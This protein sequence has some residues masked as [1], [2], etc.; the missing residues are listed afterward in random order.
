M[1]LINYYTL[2]YKVL[3]HSKNLYNLFN[4][5]IYTLVASTGKYTSYLLFQVIPPSLEIIHSTFIGE[6]ILFLH[7][8]NITI[9][10]SF[11]YVTAG[12]PSRLSPLPAIISS[13]IHDLP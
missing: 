1:Q 8:S 2:L 11:S 10:L 9:N 5:Y 7:D 4:I 13:F 12:I 6:D 3:L